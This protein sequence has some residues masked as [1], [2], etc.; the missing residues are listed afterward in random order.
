MCDAQYIDEKTHTKEFG[1]YHTDTDE[2]VTLFL[3]DFDTFTEAQSYM[4]RRFTGAIKPGGAN[5]VEILD[6]CWKVH[7]RIEVG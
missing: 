7:Q 3:D 6:Q 5:Y 1:V 2:G 4:I